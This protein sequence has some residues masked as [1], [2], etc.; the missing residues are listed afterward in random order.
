MAITL[1]SRIMKKLR[2]GIQQQERALGL[3]S[4]V[5]EGNN[6]LSPVA[7]FFTPPYFTWM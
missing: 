3:R 6:G 5:T 2:N 4:D 1:K 7:L